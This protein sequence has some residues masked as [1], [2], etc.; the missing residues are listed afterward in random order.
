MIKPPK[1]RVNNVSKYRDYIFSL[2]ERDDAKYFSTTIIFALLMDVAEMSFYELTL[3]IDEDVKNEEKLLA[4]IE[5]IAQ[6]IPYQYVLGYCDFNGNKYYVNENVLIP[7]QETEF[8]VI[9]VKD[10]IKYHFKNQTISILDMCSGSGV[11][12]IDLKLSCNADVDLVDV[13]DKANEVARSN[14]ILNKT[15]VNIYKSDMFNDL[16]VKKYDVIVCNPPYIKSEETVDEATLKYEPHLALF[17][18]PQTKFYEEVFKMRG[19]FY[20]Q[21]YILAFEIDED[22]VNDLGALINKYFDSSVKYYFEKDIYD[23]FRY[24]FIIG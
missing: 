1:W 16:P 12:G 6:G 5:K 14:A 13:S 8:L 15:N 23:K 7:R 3:N 4:N 11:I 17:A 2:K 22:M 10:L 9:K 21:K 18:S 20:D 24:L 19:L